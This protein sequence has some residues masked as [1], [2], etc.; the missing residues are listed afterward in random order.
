MADGSFGF[1]M[2]I[3]T[4]QALREAKTLSNQ[5]KNAM[6]RIDM[7]KIDKGTLQLIHSIQRML[8]ELD[9]TVKATE[10]LG[11]S[12][13]PTQ[14]FT[15]LE[16]SARVLAK[17]VETATTKV[18]GLRNSG[19][20]NTDTFK[21]AEESLARLLEK[22]SA[23]AEQMRTMRDAGA[24]Y[25]SGKDSQAY[26]DSAQTINTMT[27]NV[28]TLCEQMAQLSQAQQ[29]ESAD[30]ERMAEGMSHVGDVMEVNSRSIGSYAS[31]IRNRLT[32]IIQRLGNLLRRL[33]TG[34][35]NLTD[36]MRRATQHNNHFGRSMGSSLRNILRYTLGVSSLLALI[37]KT[38]KY[39]GEAFKVMAQEI[40]EVNSAI[41]MLGTSFKEFKAAFGTML[42]PLLQSLAPILND[43]IQKVVSLMNAVARFFATLTGQNY[44]YQATVDNYDYAESVKEAEGALASFDKLNVVQKDKDNSLAL[45][46]KNVHYE[47]VE[48]EPEDNWYTRLAE[49]IKEG[50]LKG[51]LEGVGKTIADKLAELLDSVSWDDIKAKSTKFVTTLTTGI[52]GLIMPDE[53]TG[54]SPLAKSIGSFIG[55]AIDYVLTNFST[56]VKTLHW[57]DLGN[58]I[59]TAIENLKGTLR[60][61][62]S[63]KKA[64]EA[65][66]DLF[67][68]LVDIGFELFINKNI[69]EGLGTDIATLIDEFIKKG[70]EKN[71]LTG[72]T[73]FYDL[74]NIIATALIN[75]LHEIETL[76]DKE[77]PKLVEAVNEIAQ[78]AGSNLGELFLSLGRVILKGILL[79]IKLAISAGL[80]L[81][82][83]SIDDE[84]ATFIA[85]AVGIGL[86]VSQ[87]GGL[88]T[89]I[90]GK[91][92]SGG[93]LSAFKK[94]DDALDRQSRKT[95]VES[96]LAGVLAGVLGA[97]GI[98]ALSGAEGVET[99]TDGEVAGIPVA[100]QL[101][102][103]IGDGA[104]A[105]GDLATNFGGAVGKMG[106]FE[107]KSKE[108]KT[109]VETNINQMDVK[110]PD[111]DTAALDNFQTYAHN[112]VTNIAQEF[113]DLATYIG[114]LDYTPEVNPPKTENP[115]KTS[116]PPYGMDLYTNPEYNKTYST[117]TNTP[118]VISHTPSSSEQVNMGVE[119]TKKWIESGG[120]NAEILRNTIL[121]YIVDDDKIAFLSAFYKNAEVYGF[122]EGDD[123]TELFK[124]RET[125]NTVLTNANNFAKL[126]IEKRKEDNASFG[127]YLEETLGLHKDPTTSLTTGLDNLLR[128]LPLIG[129]AAGGFPIPYLA[130]GAVI[131]PNKPFLGVLGDQKSGTNVETPLSTIEQAV[132]NVLSRMQIKN[133]FDVQGDPNRLF[134]VVQKQARIEYNQTQ[135][136]VFP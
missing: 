115:P 82:G 77:G 112:I 4:D 14:E 8:A 39:I 20:E 1:E 32:P 80:G 22:Q 17:E 50:W 123:L 88:K 55:N 70:W 135:Q 79:G 126:A 68:G 99:L 62:D 45:S 104:S 16:A 107:D 128:W 116:N 21:K 6:D 44:I 64:G 49:K 67:Q 66:G 84:L 95:A 92:G 54:E 89:A 53:V 38:R 96:A 124:S 31:A 78:G 12:K 119:G 122:K 114:G 76:I 65:F 26:K 87:I 109:A 41:S 125:F 101:A 48:F 133:V 83:I 30:A 117:G 11:N 72:N 40:P 136:S 132:A 29:Q 130:T 120:Q 74:G 71:E 58:F 91:G 3:D 42:Q 93:L 37:N 15:K 85:E 23:V 51:D 56:F 59:A 52:N 13:L 131:P 25:T 24:D 47:K 110:M 129:S 103:T 33:W 57:D 106:E 134:K 105:L 2:H 81:L 28:R 75:L 100:R 102:S 63:W 36:H 90:L 7:T 121:G 113:A 43:I 46:K 111:V 9:K 61:N 19:F 98:Q 18:N 73:Y 97:L 108:T 10:A 34:F 27:S 127:K 69:F 35:R 94:K 118:K 86:L 60:S 5:I